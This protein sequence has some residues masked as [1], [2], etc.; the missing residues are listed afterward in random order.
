MDQLRDPGRGRNRPP[1]GGWLAPAPG[2]LGA[3]AEG[4]S[5]DPTARLPLIPG[6]LDLLSSYS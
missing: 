6:S 1:G 4:G 2:H 5:Q 3:G